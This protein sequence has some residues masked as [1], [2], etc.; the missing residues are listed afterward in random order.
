MELGSEKYRMRMICSFWVLIRCIK[1]ETGSEKE[2]LIEDIV[3]EAKVKG[4]DD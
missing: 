1:A 2:V 3:E 4:K